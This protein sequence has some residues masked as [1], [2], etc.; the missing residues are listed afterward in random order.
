MVNSRFS[1]IASSRSAIPWDG[2]QLVEPN[3]SRMPIQPNRGHVPLRIT[4]ARPRGRTKRLIECNI[5]ELIT[6][7]HSEI[8]SQLPVRRT[9]HI[10]I[11]EG[12]CSDTSHCWQN[13][14]IVRVANVAIYGPQ[15]AQGP[16]NI[17]A[18]Y[19]AGRSQEES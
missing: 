5:V 19:V 17:K 2:F 7:V 3:G 13:L 1:I 16:R 14:A 6:E 18:R 4:A 12:L 8:S 11:L 10:Q 9:S 15:P